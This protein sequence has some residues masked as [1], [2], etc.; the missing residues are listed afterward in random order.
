MKKLFLL[1]VLF[2]AFFFACAGESTVVP[3]VAVLDFAARSRE[4]V[5]SDAGKSVAELLTVGL[6][7]SGSVDLVERAELDK[8]LTELHLSAIGLTDRESQVKLGKIIG[9]KILVTGSIFKAGNKNYIVAKMIGTETS[10]VFG[11]S[12]NG[13][14]DFASLV[15]ELINKISNMLSNQA[16]KLLPAKQNTNKVLE[17]LAKTVKGNNRTVY[18]KVKED[19]AV[20]V[21][22]PAVETELKKLM[23][24][25]GFSVVKE[26]SS[27]DFAIIGEAVAGNAGSYRS[28]TSAAA[29]VELSVYAKGGKLLSTGAARETLA[30]GAYV[31]TAKEALAQC[32]LKL[33]SELF[34]VMK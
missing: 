13:E 5:S 23:L 31:I 11:S 29:R 30:G 17:S 33:A 21:P 9:A 18:I 3:T 22:D 24:A 26:R 6:M 15:P 16:A 1:A 34:G 2:T 27:A 8:A 20:A 19:I 12:V 25:L 28:F 32:G 7:E 10:R 14:G 4:A